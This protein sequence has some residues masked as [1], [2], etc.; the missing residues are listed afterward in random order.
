MFRI[1]IIIIAFIGAAMLFTFTGCDPDGTGTG[2]N[3]TVNSPFVDIFDDGSMTNVTGDD[4][5]EPGQV[6]RVQIDALSNEAQLRDIQVLQNFF[7]LGTD[8][9]DNLNI[10]DADEQNPQ[11]L[12]GTD[13][14]A[15]NWTFEFVAPEAEGDFV[16][17]FEVTDDAGLTSTATVNIT[18]IQTVADTPASV[19][20]NGT[21]P[22]EAE[23]G[24]LVS[25]NITATAGTN[26]FA[27]LSVWEDGAIIEDTTRLR[28]LDTALEAQFSTNPLALAS[29]ESE[30]FSG[31]IFIRSIPGDHD[32]VIRLTDVD[33]VDTDVTFSINEIGNATAL[34]SEFDFV[35]FS[36]ASGPDNGGLDLDNGVAVPSA[37]ANAEIRDLGIDTNQP[38]AS[39]WI[40]SVEG[41]NGTD[42]RVVDINSLPEGF[43]AITSKEQITAAF[44][45]G[46]P[47]SPTPT[48]QVGDLLVASSFSA[49]YIMRVDEVNVTDSDNNDFYRFSIKF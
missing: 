18:V 29:P 45:A 11:L 36:N 21:S 48:L 20:L 40:Q 49:I 24:N 2:T 31:P 25:V 14:D 37:S 19:T 28:F 7:S 22:F 39:N 4:T 8:E 12:F 17:D 47:A 41:V 3:P 38:A 23:A 32:Y 46:T 33:G 44:N 27:T 35:L 42:L 15:F 26:S 5:V 34:T 1:K 10:D 16:Y 30:G 43:D 9:F 6:F 13:K